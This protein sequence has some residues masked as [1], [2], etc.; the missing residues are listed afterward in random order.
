MFVLILMSKIKKVG[1]WSSEEADM[2]L[3]PNPMYRLLT[4]SLP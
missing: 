3:L 4:V 2:P 1:S